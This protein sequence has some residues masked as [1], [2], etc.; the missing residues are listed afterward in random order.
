M[1]VPLPDGRLRPDPSAI[2]RALETVRARIGDAARA[3]GRDPASVELVAVSKF[4]PKEAVLA[5][6]ACRQLVFGENRVQEAAGKFDGLNAAHPGL[7][8]HLIG[9]IQTNKASDAV[10]IAD[11][12]ETV[13]RPRLADALDAAA[14]KQGRLPTLLVQVNIGQ[15]PQKAGIAP[16]EADRFIADCRRRFGARLVGLMAIPPAGADP[17][18]FF[19]RMASLAEAHGLDRLS[20]GMSDDFASAIR[21]GA[22]S[23]RIGSAIFG[24]RPEHA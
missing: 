14:Q 13:D 3:A 7:R 4:P 8:L 5:A 12:I 11:M 6:L 22:T 1:T 21:H 24:R 23:V 2:A 17:S 19:G 16:G 10:R 15:E 20:M 9:P 18:P